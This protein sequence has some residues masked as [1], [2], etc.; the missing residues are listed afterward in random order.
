MTYPAFESSLAQP[1][2][3][4]SRYSFD[5]GGEKLPALLNRWQAEY[6]LEWVRLAIIEALYLGRYKV[7]SVENILHM[8]RSRSETKVH[9]NHDFERFVFRKMPRDW[10]Q[11]ST[12]SVDAP[13]PTS[14]PELFRLKPKTVASEHASLD[15]TRNSEPASSLDDSSEAFFQDLHQR[16]DA[17]KTH[18]PSSTFPAAPDVSEHSGLKQQ[19]EPEQSKVK[20]LS[21]SLSTLYF[22]HTPPDPFVSKL[23]KFA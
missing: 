7:I 9:F 4:L 3:L 10:P 16:V 19:R 5:L 11:K 20:S 23:K 6:T 8:W 18:R 21:S 17:M 2:I 14:V 1:A 12:L 22:E 15:L 13:A